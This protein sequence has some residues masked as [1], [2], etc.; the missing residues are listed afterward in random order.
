M[1][2][3]NEHH[4]G[5]SDPNPDLHPP[6]PASPHPQP[7]Y[8]PQPQE[9]AKSSSPPLHSP[10]IS[11]TPALDL[12]TSRQFLTSLITA[13]S[14]IPLL[15]EPPTQIHK[16]APGP[17]SKPQSKAADV[18]ATE[19]ETTIRRKQLLQILKDEGDEGREEDDHDVTIRNKNMNKI[20]I[21][22]GQVNPLKLVP[23][24]YRHLIITLHVLFP[25]VVLPGLEVLER[26]LVERVILRR[27]AAGEGVAAAVVKKKKKK[28]EEEEEE[29][30]DEEGRQKEQMKEGDMDVDMDMDMDVDVVMEEGDD[31]RKNDDDDDGDVTSPPPAED[32][33]KDGGKAKKNHHKSLWEESTEAKVEHHP[34]SPPPE[35]YLVRSSQ[36]LNVHPKRKRKYPSSNLSGLYGDADTEGIPSGVGSEADRERDYRIQRYMVSL[37]AW[38]CTCA[39]FAFACVSEPEA[40]DDAKETGGEEL[41]EKRESDNKGS[42]GWTFGGMTLFNARDHS[43]VP[44]VCKHLLACLL[45]DKWTR[46]LGRYVTDR[47]V[48]R[49]EMAGIVADV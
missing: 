10:Q 3:P 35:F 12:P 41:Q 16:P 38:N 32:E 24:E 28:E 15:D 29:E 27:C 25:G 9:E 36:F 33:T 23:P 31:N 48:S 11:T 19:T 14:N 17:G 5:H 47:V 43:S 37:E 22:G 44:P 1:A 13:I 20:K 6:G 46:A 7:S 2:S 8:Q 45:A 21:P 18:P 39:A 4:H 42:A 49:E 40:G 30:E 26:G 34:R